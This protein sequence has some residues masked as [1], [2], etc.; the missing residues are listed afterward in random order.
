MVLDLIA[1]I[2]F[3]I[4]YLLKGAIFYSFFTY[5][6][7]LVAVYVRKIIAE[8]FKLNWLL[9]T[10]IVTYLVLFLI[11]FVIY[12]TPFF[13]SIGETQTGIIPEPFAQTNLEIV[14][15]IIFVFLRLVLVVAVLTLLVLPLEF[16]GVFIF[17]QIEERNPKGYYLNIA[18]ATFATVLITS[19][20]VLFLAP[21]II[22][23]VLFLIF[24]SL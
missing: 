6:I 23:G 1:N 20:V 2:F 21:W 16:I 24:F 15:G 22:P 4:A 18:L 10:A 3:S 8:K 19:I 14:I 12:L 5:I 13:T 17:E 9:S 11:I 7:V